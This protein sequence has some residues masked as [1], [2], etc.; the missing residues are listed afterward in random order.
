MK[1]IEACIKY[2]VS[3]IVCILLA[4]LFG[5]ISVYRIPMQMIPTID[6]PEV[7]VETVYLGAAPMEVEEEITDKQEEKLNSVE[8]LREITSN[9]LEGKSTIVLKYDWGTNKDVARLDVSEKLGLVQERPDDA[10][11]PIIKAVNS[12][13]DTPIAWIILK[14]KRDINE[15]REEAEDVIKPRFE[16]V[17]GVGTVWMFGGQEREVHLILD[18][19]ALNARNISIPEVRDALLRENR[20][21]KGGNID[22]GK[23]KYVVRT[24]GQF[25]DLKQIENVIITQR[26]GGPVYIR[27]VAKVKFG[28]RDR[29][30]SVRLWGEP[31]I[32][33]GILRKTG[34]NTIEVMEGVR[35]EVKF[36]NEE[37]YKGKDIFLQQVYDETEYIDDSVNLVTSNLYT[38]AVLATIVLTLFLKNIASTLIIAFSIPISIITTFIFLDFFGR[39]VNIIS[40]AGLAFATGMVVDNAIVVLENIFRHRQM[41][42]DLVRAAYDGTV[43]VWGAVLASTLTTLA[44]F[45]PILFVREEAGQLFRDIVITLSI[46]IGLSMLV[47]LTVIPMLSSRLL[48]MKESVGKSKFL[49]KLISFFT[50]DWLGSGFTNLVVGFVTRMTR[51][52]TLRAATALVIIIL[53]GWSSYTFMPPIDYLPKGNRNLIFGIIKTPPGFNINQQEKIIKELEARVLTM[54]EIDRF[55][56]VGRTTDASILGII[57]KKEYADLQNMG[58]LVQKLRQSLFGVPGTIGV[59]ITQSPLFRRTGSFFGGT[60]VEVN[61]KG[62]DLKQIQQISTN[63]ENQIKKLDGVNFVNSSFELGNPELQVHVDSQKAADLG[64]SVSQ[65]GYIVE[66]LVK[67]TK[68]GVFR[69]GGKEIDIVLKGSEVVVDQTEYLNTMLLPTPAGQFIRLPD[70]A[71]IRLESGPTKIEHLDLDRSIKLIVNAR[72]DLALETLVNRINTEVVDKVRQTLPLGYTINLS[73]QAK[74]LD[75]TWNV[76]KWSFLLALIIIYLLMCS[77]FESFTYP[78]IIMFSVPLAASGGILAVSLLHSIEPNIKMDVITMLGFVIL[79]GTV[80]NNAILI[81]H[82]TLN[83]VQY[84]FPI[85]EALIESCRTRLRPIFM[86]ATTSIF[87]MLP[88]VVSSGAGSELYRGLG[89]AVLGGLSMSTIFTL[90]LVPAVFLLWLD[91]QSTLAFLFRRAPVEE[92]TVGAGQGV[93]EIVHDK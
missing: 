5:V 90:V 34:A 56:A 38:G 39:S 24:L 1:I 81:I 69:E 26:D 16:R 23:R 9:S 6:R 35:K 8:N 45:I 88:L 82:Q 7:S 21:V 83:N 36:L 68:A 46:S 11:Q 61:V 86:T 85:R 71:E 29:D 66:T 44:V 58:K 28:Y 67:G 19:Y 20:N 75:V 55:F 57:A 25:T 43:E 89:A 74:D 54:P 60:N 3:V 52:F 65:I 15:I 30:F 78:F 32:A 79:A 13:E 91:L 42:K 76:L 51:S 77:L 93:W 10:D 92:A 73:G 31:T 33:F 62:D 2:P 17:N 63:L 22:E 48:V 12:D 4:I 53:A 47:S 59:F 72:E 84:G 50:L 70:I 14:T 18:H 80:V 40:L 64:L 41:S 27:D 37:I 87:G 49:Q